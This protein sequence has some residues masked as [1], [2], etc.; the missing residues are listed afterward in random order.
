MKTSTIE[1]SIEIRY[2][3]VYSLKSDEYNED[4]YIDD[5]GLSL[6]DATMEVEK[7][8]KEH[9]GNLYSLAIN[10]LIVNI[11]IDNEEIVTRDVNYLI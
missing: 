11:S 5:E 4:I 6:V 10:T 9:E 1:K 8:K 2:E 3:V 7:I